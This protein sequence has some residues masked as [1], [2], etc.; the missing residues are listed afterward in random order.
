MSKKTKQTTLFQTWGYEGNGSRANK[1][2]CEDSLATFYEDD[3][4]DDADLNRALELSMM[5]V[6][7][8]R[9]VDPKVGEKRDQFQ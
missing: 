7:K 9:T 1:S 4:A 8:E 6:Q 2:N 3:D 5:E